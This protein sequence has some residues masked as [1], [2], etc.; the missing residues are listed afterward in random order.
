MHCLRWRFAECCRARQLPEAVAQVVAAH[1]APGFFAGVCTRHR[2]SKED[3]QMHE[4]SAPV[5]S[6]MLRKYIY[7]AY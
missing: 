4:D 1:T 5:Q 6:H 2:P 7:S 3:P